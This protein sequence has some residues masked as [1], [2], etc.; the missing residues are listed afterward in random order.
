M[1]IDLSTNQPVEHKIVVEYVDDFYGPIPEQARE[2][3]AA[4]EQQILE[5]GEVQVPD[6]CPEEWEDS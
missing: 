6:F 3:I 4:E 1:A 2:R 5:S